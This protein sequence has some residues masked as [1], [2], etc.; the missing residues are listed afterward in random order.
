MIA[1]RAASAARAASRRSRARAA[2]TAN[3]A[4]RRSCSGRCCAARGAISLTSSSSRRGEKELDAIRPD[5]P[6]SS[7]DR[8]RPS[9]ARAPATA[10]RSRAGA[11]VIA[12][13]PRSCSFSRRGTLRRRR[14][15]RA[16]RPRSVRAK[17]D[18]ALENQRRAI[19][20]RQRVLG[21][22][23]SMRRAT[24]LC[25]RSRRAWF[26]APPEIRPSPQPSRDRRP[27]SH[28]RERRRRDAA[29]AHE[30]FS[31]MRSWVMRSTAL[32]GETRWPS[33]SSVRPRRSR[34]SRTRR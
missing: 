22:V 4:S 14:R 18:E 21:L 20:F 28:R 34:C 19:C 24:A 7:S 15:R 2:R 29:L 13:M 1:L 5:D 33:R 17:R 25:R 23:D 8:P 6:Q 9:P 16:S 31:R 30:R 10:R 26:S 32:P 27:R 12:R 11:I 3:T